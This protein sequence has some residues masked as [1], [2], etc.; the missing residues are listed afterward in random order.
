MILMKKMSSGTIEDLRNKLQT[1]IELEHS[2]IPPYLTANFT[3]INQS[4][5]TNNNISGIIGSVLGEEMLH[6]TIAANI[7]N[8][9]GGQPVINKPDFIPTY[10]GNLP[11]SVDAGLTVGLEKFSLDLVKNVFMEIEEPENPVDIKNEIQPYSEGLTIGE[12]YK[13]IIQDM[14]ALQAQGNIFTGDPAL[15]VTMENFYPSSVLFPV[16]NLEE[17]I[18]AI[19]II[20]DQ[21]EGTS[22][23]PFVAPEDESYG[24]AEPAHYY[25]FEEIVKGQEL[26]QNKDGSYAY[27]GNPIPFDPTAVA[28]MWP[29]PRMADYPKD[30]LAYENIRLFNYN[31][32]CLLN[33]LHDTFNGAP[34]KI[35]TALGNMFTLRLYALKLLA[36]PS[37]NHPGFVAGPSF[38]YL[39]EL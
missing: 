1:A 30:S 31:Y 19:N 8:A 18:Q 38:E 26:V 39:P 25:R 29:N 5:T 14:N 12:F 22:T 34:D 35:Q 28:N 3:L 9:I 4:S 36:L 32:T 10:P 21:G 6:M 20:I 17:A 11:G 16:T 37:P 13:G 24:T 15:Q 7:L 33:T 2:T 27:T 23:D